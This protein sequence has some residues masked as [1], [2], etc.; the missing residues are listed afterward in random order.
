MWLQG[1]SSL[2]Q[3]APSLGREVVCQSPLVTPILMGAPVQFHVA[4]RD[5]DD[6]QLR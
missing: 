1:A 3:Q 2:W 5:L 6:A 4:L